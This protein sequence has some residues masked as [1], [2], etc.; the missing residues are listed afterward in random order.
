[1]FAQT[2]LFVVQGAHIAYVCSDCTIY[3]PRRPYNG[4]TSDYTYAFLIRTSKPW[5]LPDKLA[6]SSCNPSLS[7]SLPV[8]HPCPS[9]PLPINHPF[10]SLSLSLFV[11]A[12]N[13]WIGC[14]DC[15][16]Q[17]PLSGAGHPG[18]PPSCPLSP[19]LEFCSIANHPSL[20]ARNLTEGC[21]DLNVSGLGGP[22]PQC[23][24]LQAVPEWQ[25]NLDVPQLWWWVG[26]LVCGGASARGLHNKCAPR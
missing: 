6:S 16:T 19:D 4:L 21:Q 22:L 18:R 24:S 13:S 26:A 7:L 15:P 14:P 20:P 10:P 1:M 12:H 17:L 23:P 9:L 25:G 5:T 8:T 11:L 3:S 2:V